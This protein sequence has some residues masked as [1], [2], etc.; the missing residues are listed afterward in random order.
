MR[1]LEVRGAVVRYGELVAIDQVDLAVEPGEIVALL[2]ASGSGKSSLLRGIAGLEPLAAGRVGWDGDD[3]SAAPVHARGFGMMFQDGQLFQHLSVEGNI[4]YGL[5]REPRA[6]RRAR[7]AELLGVVGLPGY[8]ARRVG[9]LS[10]GQAQRVAL[11]RSLAPRPRLL[12]LDEPLSA[13]DRNLREHLV[14]VLGDALRAT[15]TTALY[16]TH[17][18]D[19]AFALADRVGVMAE[20]R[21]LQLDAPEVLWRRPASR[22]VAEF[23]GYEPFIAADLAA[24]LGRV[25]AGV[26]ELVAIGP[27]GLVPAPTGVE[28]P[29]VEQRHQRGEVLIDVRLPD[30][31]TATARSAE[32]VEGESLTVALD[33]AGC[34]VIPR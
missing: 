14:G 22:Q 3:V 29:I 34:A 32:R 31:Q 28:V 20:G 2:G 21:M 4:G 5:Y 10:G 13:L 33:P 23:L 27:A 15:G 17:D 6:Q 25:R 11:A 24:R 16:V 9:E 12:L 7:V 26:D 30:G 1:G 19:E 8:Q 18:Q